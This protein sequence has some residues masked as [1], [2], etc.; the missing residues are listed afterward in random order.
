MCKPH[1]TLY[2]ID[3]VGACN[4]RCPSCPVGNFQSNDFVNQSRPKGFM[5]LSL[6]ED[7]LD[8]IKREDNEH[9]YVVI[10]VYNWGEPLLH[11]EYP[12]F[13]DAIKSRGFYAEVSTNLNVKK[14]KDV[15][16][17][18]PHKLII[19]LSG[20]HREV[21]AKTHSNGDANLMVSNL[22]KLRYYMDKLKQNFA[23][24]ISYHLYE[25][26]V[27]E[28]LERMMCIANDLGFHFSSELTLLMPLEKNFKY[29]RG[30]QLSELEQKLISLML[31]KP[32]EQLKLAQ[33]YKNTSCSLLNWKTINFDGSMATCCAV[34]DYEYNIT[35]NFLK[36]SHTELEERK[37][38]SSLCKRCMVQGLH[39]LA[40]YTARDELDKLINERLQKFGS[41][42]IRDASHA[43]HYSFDFH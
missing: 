36:V 28:D 34:Y 14:V 33:P 7:I 37:R 35:N 3:I 1:F 4:L 29:L 39:A 18:A 22:Y 19:S 25:H 42:I 16:S 40:T 32:E 9:E 20:Y 15:V 2:F 30:E 24:E 10:G 41:K 12:K 26:N 6:F 31:I 38:N 11:P 27:G 17:F 21:Y 23:V 5:Q 43:R 13:I 8:K